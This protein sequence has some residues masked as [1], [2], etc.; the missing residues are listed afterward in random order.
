MRFSNAA[1][2]AVIT[3]LLAGTANAATYHVATNGSDSNNG[4][5][6]APFRTLTR[7]T[8]GLRPG[9]VVNV[10]GG[11]Y[12]E[13]VQINV[14]GTAAERITIRSYP[15]ET[16]IFDGTGT[17]RNENV[18]TLYKSAY[19]DLSGFE[20]RNAGQIGICSWGS[21]NVRILNNRVHHSF[22]NGIYV[23]WDVMGVSYDNVVDGNTV[24]NNVLENANREFPNGGWATGVSMNYTDRG[25]VTNNRIYENDGEGIVTILA[26]YTHIEG[27]EL[28]DNFSVGIY[29]DNSRYVK[30]NANLMYSTGNSRYYREGYPASG[31]AT[32]NEW[33]DHSLPSSDNIFTNNIVINSRWGFFYGAYQRGGGL[34]N[35]VVANNTFYKSASTM[36][37]IEDDSHA[38]NHFE[39]NIFYQLGG[40][41][42]LDVHGGGVTYKNNVWYGAPVAIAS[43]NDVLADPKFVNP[44]GFKA[45]DYKLTNLSPALTVG[46][47]LSTI[48]TKDFFGSPR[49]AAFD[50]GAH[51]F[52]NSSAVTPALAS[53]ANLRGAATGTR[54]IALNW[55][56]T[57]NV[58]YAVYRDG[59]KIATVATP[60]FIDTGL[61]PNTI[62]TYQVSAFAGANE[63]PRSIGVPVKTQANPRRR[64]VR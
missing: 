26:K 5:L 9:D 42:M 17:G 11:V 64:A 54:S 58:Q 1:A 41:G 34:R 29:V 19:V 25:R 46:A 2:V 21:N 63:S 56:S 24:H 43:A 12:F 30:V 4:S 23:G 52:T 6:N 33:Y 44:G 13:T 8:E 3:V 35:A 45:S 57:A 7:A 16:A 51:Q 50:I 31:M 14:K 15:G 10:R 55:A 20:V 53:P 36:L 40:R 48:V 49:S 22:R 61:T 62:Y 27:N 59:T 38:N 28:S 47:N 39:N 32:A 37:W 60:E 18:L